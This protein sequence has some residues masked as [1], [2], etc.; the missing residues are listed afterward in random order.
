M[1]GLVRPAT[2]RR[3]AAA[4]IAVVA[5]LHDR[6]RLA[7]HE[8]IARQPNPFIQEAVPRSEPVVVGLSSADDFLDVVVW[9]PVVGI[10]DASSQK[11]LPPVPPI[12]LAIGMVVRQAT[13]P[14]RTAWIAVD[15]KVEAPAAL[16]RPSAVPCQRV[17][18][19]S[20]LGAEGPLARPARRRASTTWGS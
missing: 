20:H 3:Q 14:S 2:S 8:A 17:S 12:L 16:G 13:D 18:F 15:D 5:E 10:G 7:D 11:V 6:D 19:V 4:R 9:R 1:R